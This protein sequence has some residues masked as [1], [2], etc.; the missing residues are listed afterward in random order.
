[1]A[2]FRQNAWAMEFW[3]IC[4]IVLDIFV[5]FLQN[6]SIDVNRIWIRHS[7]KRGNARSDAW[8]ISNTSLADDNSGRYLPV[9]VIEVFKH[10]SF[11]SIG[12]SRKAGGGSTHLE[13]FVKDE[14][15]V[16][17]VDLPRQL[18]RFLST[19]VTI[20]NRLHFLIIG[21][22]N[23]KLSL[24]LVI[25]KLFQQFVNAFGVAETYK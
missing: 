22:L 10:Y 4:K 6:C 16:S 1:M 2:I 13:D 9:N 5:S 7:S 11:A 21:V 3:K 8:N 14:V 24:L 20:R 15:F 17:I 25:E 19:H 12:I 18:F 23:L